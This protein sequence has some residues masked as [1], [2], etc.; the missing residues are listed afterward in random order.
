MAM[1]LRDEMKLALETLGLQE[2]ASLTGMHL[3]EIEE[4]ADSVLDLL[5]TIRAQARQHDIE[6]GNDTLAELT[7]AL[8]HLLHHVQEVLPGLHKQ[9]D[10][11]DLGV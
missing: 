5:I 8:D 6:T 11:E 2:E 4:E 3:S 10:L 9:L 7:V 1:Q